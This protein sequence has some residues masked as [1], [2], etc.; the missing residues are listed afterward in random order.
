MR[1]GA[2]GW[3]RLCSRAGGVSEHSSENRRRKTAVARW[4]ASLK[5]FRERLGPV[6]NARAH[7]S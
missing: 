6:D 5:A 4:P 7:A 2:C 3:L 1:A